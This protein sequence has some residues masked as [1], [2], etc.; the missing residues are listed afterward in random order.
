MS[1]CVWGHRALRFA[2]PCKLGV[3]LVPCPPTPN[4][5][6]SAVDNSPSDWHRGTSP[7]RAFS[8]QRSQRSTRS[9]SLLWGA[10]FSEQPCS[11]PSSPIGVERPCSA[12]PHAL[13]QCH[14]PRRRYEDTAAFRRVKL[15]IFPRSAA[16]RCALSILDARQAHRWPSRW[17]SADLRALSSSRPS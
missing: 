10:V 1:Q 12:D 13:S 14:R 9:S 16:P 15:P 11:P 17:R 8:A 4:V 6:A 2:H 3:G 7:L 5:E